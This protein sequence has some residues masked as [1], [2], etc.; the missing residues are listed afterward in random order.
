MFQNKLCWIIG[1]SDGIGKSIALQLHEKGA[2]V[3][4]SSRNEQKLFAIKDSLTD[5]LSHVV[6]L[7]LENADSIAAAAKQVKA[8]GTPDFVFLVGGISQRDNFLETNLSTGK[9]IFETNFWGHVQVVQAILPDMLLMQRSYIIEISSITGKFGYHRRSFYSASKHAV[10]GFFESLA[11]EYHKQGLRVCLA[12]PGK[13]QTDIA[14]RALKGSGDVW[15]EKE[16]SHEEG[17]PVEECARIILRDVEKG[18]KTSY[19]GGKEM[20]SVLLNRF[21]PNVLFKILLNKNDL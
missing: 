5:L 2:S 3:I 12:Y 13:I 9:R 16:Q 20:L 19:P 18:K 6:P 7:D 8:I 1:A 17:M 11:L 21:M 10:K 14:L 15:N 4:L